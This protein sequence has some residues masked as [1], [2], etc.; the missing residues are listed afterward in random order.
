[1]STNAKKNKQKRIKNFKTLEER[2]SIV[3]ETMSKLKEVHLIGMD[4][5]GECYSSFDGVQELLTI[6]NEYKKPILLSGLSGIIKVPELQR[7]IE[8]IL[9]I[10]KEAEHVIR[11][12]ATT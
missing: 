1:M 4:E 10:R 2:T 7:N 5:G 8:Y 6:L 11:L 3:D 9:P 12:I